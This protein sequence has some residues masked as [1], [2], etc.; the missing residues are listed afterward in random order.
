[1]HEALGGATANADGD[2]DSSTPATVTTDTD[3]VRRRMA[4]P[5]V[6]GKSWQV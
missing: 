3:S 1:M 6:S 2:I 4:P 5:L